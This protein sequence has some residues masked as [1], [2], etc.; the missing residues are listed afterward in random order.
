ME[1]SIEIGGNKILLK[2][3]KFLTKIGEKYTNKGTST[4]ISNPNSR[5]INPFTLLINFTID[6]KDKY[7]LIVQG[8]YK[9][10]YKE[11]QDSDNPITNDEM[12]MV[13]KN[14]TKEWFL[15]FT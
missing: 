4:I 1:S 7:Q 15:K 3:G 5:L 8:D 2:I 9:D 12:F 13:I 6:N 10:K 14:H 11:K